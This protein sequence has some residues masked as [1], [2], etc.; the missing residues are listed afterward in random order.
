MKMKE[1]GCRLLITRV[2][3]FGEPWEE[4]RAKNMWFYGKN[5]WRLFAPTEFEPTMGFK[6]IS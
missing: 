1:A 6:G 2:G 5:G 3:W 4:K